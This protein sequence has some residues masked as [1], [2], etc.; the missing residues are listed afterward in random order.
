MVIRATPSSSNII[1]SVGNIYRNT[2][3]IPHC[4]QPSHFPAYVS[5]D[6]GSI[7]LSSVLEFYLVTDN[8]LPAL[9]N[10]RDPGLRFCVFAKHRCA[11]QKLFV[12]LSQVKYPHFYFMSLCGLWLGQSLLLHLSGI[13][14]VPSIMSEPHGVPSTFG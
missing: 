7:Y 11:L 4:R 6:L 12:S 5:Y 9:E 3:L 10:F 13:V 2:I 14:F 8:F 1:T